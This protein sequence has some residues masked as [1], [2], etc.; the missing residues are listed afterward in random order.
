MTHHTQSGNL[1]EQ[2]QGYRRYS[3]KPSPYCNTIPCL[4]AA[5]KPRLETRRYN[6]NTASGIY[7]GMFFCA[8][9]FFPSPI[10]VL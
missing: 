6:T 7:R 5:Q 4:C 2:R 10:N 8:S 3:D 9:F 1:L